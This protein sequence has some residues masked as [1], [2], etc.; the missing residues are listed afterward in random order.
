MFIDILPDPHPAAD[1]R[2]VLDPQIY[3]GIVINLIPYSWERVRSNAVRLF[4]S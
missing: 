2:V 1:Q 4:C 3:R